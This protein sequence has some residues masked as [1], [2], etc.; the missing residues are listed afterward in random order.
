MPQKLQYFF[1]NFFTLFFHIL[2]VDVVHAS[3]LPVGEGASEVIL[4]IVVHNRFK[5][6][7]FAVLQQIYNMHLCGNRQI[8]LWS[9]YMD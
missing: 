5:E 1:F 7:K 6:L 2:L 4:N 3:S 8:N 9:S